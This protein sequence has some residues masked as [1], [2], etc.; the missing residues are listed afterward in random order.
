MRQ[1]LQVGKESIAASIAGSVAGSVAGIIAAVFLTGLCGVPF[2]SAQVSN[3][4]GAYRLFSQ[5]AGRVMAMGGAFVAIVDDATAAGYNPAGAA[6]SKWRFDFG[7]TNNRVDDRADLQQS[8]YSSFQAVTEAYSFVSYAVAARAG[9]FVFGMGVS[10]P[11]Q[12]HYSDYLQ[13]A[14]I[15][16]MRYDAMLSWRMGN[17]FAMGI[18]GHHEDLREHFD[19]SSLSGEAR[20]TAISLS[21]GALY[22]TRK[23]GIGVVYFQGHEIPVTET[24]AQSPVIAAWLR[25]VVVPAATCVGGFYYLHERFMIAVDVDR[26]EIPR[27]VIDASSA[28]QMVGEVSLTPGTQQVLHGGFEWTLIEDRHMN[29]VFRGGGYVEPAR[30]L[31]SESRFHRTYG[32]QVQFGPAVLTVSFD[33]ANNFSNTSQGFSLVLGAI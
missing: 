28:L 2:A 1:L 9:S 5:G 16:L 30:I 6:L 12:Y 24:G 15:V 13:N 7:G 31:Y 22:R 4:Y 11:Y 21:G 14:S 25:N 3:N 8:S 32:L 19:Q 23:A 17:S 26:F 33:Q 29:I 27:N 10:T 20:G 18:S